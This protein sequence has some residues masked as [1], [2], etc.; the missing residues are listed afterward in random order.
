MLSAALEKDLTQ[1]GGGRFT[2]IV[3]TR[4][5]QLEILRHELPCLIDESRSDVS[6]GTSMPALKL[7]RTD[8]WA[9]ITKLRKAT[10]DESLPKQ[11]GRDE[12]GELASNLALR[13]IT[14]AVFVML[15]VLRQGK[16]PASTLLNPLRAPL[17]GISGMVAKNLAY[18][19]AA[20]AGFVAAALLVT[21]RLLATDPDGSVAVNKIDWPAAAATVLA[22]ALVVGIVLV[23]AGRAIHARGI[24]GKLLEG[25]AAVA[26]AATGGLVAVGLAATAGS[27]D[28]GQI[29]FAPGADRL[30]RW[31]AWLIIAVLVGLPLVRQVPVVG[32]R[33]NRIIERPFAGWI[34]LIPVAL[35]V[36]GSIYWSVDELRD[37]NSPEWWQTTSIVLAACSAL[38]AIV[39]IVFR[40][41]IGRV[42]RRK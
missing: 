22:L 36:G 26:L 12:P 2:T 29:V 14:H 23:A 20:A 34:G 18:R 21:A 28:A 10:G 17:F 7:S 31:V 25:V 15:A 5:V 27:L 3:C 37:V 30:Y 42:L 24:G 38:V 16:V 40:S 39:Y 41:T 6:E 32:S 4:A 19:F 35:A 33:F 13:T 1:P 9:A 8:T 11:L